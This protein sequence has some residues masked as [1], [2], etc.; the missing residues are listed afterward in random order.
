VTVLLTGGTGIVGN[1][2]ARA[3]VDRGRKVRALVRSLERG[4]ALLPPICELVQGDVT[5][6]PSIRRALD[7][8]TTVYHAAGLPEQWL[9]DPST[10]DRVNAGGTANMVEAALAT[11]VEKFVYTSTIDVFA[12]APG[13]EF[14]ESTIATEPKGTHYERSKQ[15]ADRLVTA[16]VGRGLPAVFLH[17]SAVYGPIAASSPGLNDFIA[18]L[19]RHE[20]PM[21]LPGGMPV[22]YAPDVGAGHV[23]AEEHGKPGARFILSESCWTLAGIARAV[24]D[25][26]GLPRIPRVMPSA[27]AHAVAFAGEALSKLTRRPPLLPRGQLHFL[28]LD[29]RPSGRRARD[30]LGWSPMPFREA[31]VPTV[32][33]LERGRA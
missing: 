2:I 32:A 22:V 7:G 12:A 15:E 3:L 10:F 19:L 8:C 4:R 9:R 24:A 23:L 1:A 14:D 31:L 18:Q 30:E 26:V 28:E 17:P 33:F 21:L 11:R 27:V 25:T 20:V 5:D 29:S 13:R 6:P 16:A